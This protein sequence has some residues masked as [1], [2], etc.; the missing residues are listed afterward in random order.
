MPSEWR[1]TTVGDLVELQRG[2]TY[3]SRLLGLPGPALLGLATIQR[4]GGF[5]SDIIQTYGGESPDKLL[6]EPG[7][8]YVSLKDVTQAADLLGA[9]ARVPRWVAVGRLTQDTVKLLFKRRDIPRSLV[10]WVLR[11]PQYRHYCRARATGTTNLAL[12]R[13]DFLSYPVPEPSAARRA[14]TNLLDALDDKIEL[15]RKMN[16]TLEQMAQALFKSWFVD[17]EPFRDKGMVESPLG[18]I[19]KGW[20]VGTLNDVAANPRRSV[21]PG[22]IRPGTPYIALEHMHRKSICL[23]DWS[24]GDKV[25]SGKSAFRRGEILFGKLR[26]YFHKVGVAPLDGVCSTDILVVAPKSPHW[27]GYVLGHVSSDAFV[28]YANAGSEGTKMPRTNWTR[29]AAYSLAIP[30]DSAAGAFNAVVAPALECI[31]QNIWQSRTLAAIRDALLPKLMS[32]EV[33]ADAPE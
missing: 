17:F 29:M 30:T 14:L 31:T 8:L 24:Q 32:G 18:K 15:N 6:L 23:G 7:D 25:E 26:P 2:T 9:V 11:T 3:K 10:Y 21:G 16:E 28:A 4:N 12:S 22:E 19:P 13:E 33:N 1:E 27:L 20:K 5:R